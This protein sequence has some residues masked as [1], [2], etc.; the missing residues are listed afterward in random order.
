MRTS[1]LLVLSCLTAIGGEAIAALSLVN[2]KAVLP[3][4]RI[5]SSRR[6]PEFSARLSPDGKH[7]LFPQKVEGQDKTYRLVLLDIERHKETEISI[8]LPGGYE[9]VF[10]RFNF[11][12]P[13]GNKLALFYLK[14]YPSKSMAEIVIYD[15]ARNA[16]TKTNIAGRST[17]AQ[18][19]STGEHLVVSQHNSYVAL[20]TL[21]DFALG[22]PLES[23][24]VHSCSPRSPIAAI[25]QQ[26]NRSEM[27]VG[28]K[29]LNLDSKE[30][31][32]LPVHAKNSRLDDVTSQWSLDGRYIFYLDYEGGG[33][34]IPV[35][36]VWDT[37]EDQEKAAVEN[38]ICLGP[39][40][41]SRLML[42]ASADQADRGCVR[43]YDIVSESL[44]SVGDS[45]MKAVH[46]W[47]DRIIYVA[48]ENGTESLYVA[49]IIDE[50]GHQ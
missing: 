28:F 31:T 48:T 9:T 34:L 1:F 12:D 26:P 15:I 13:S 2:P 30:V 10:T 14:D 21:D 36:R 38:V 23:G 29:L 17:M 27:Q 49:E 24:W 32:Q 40:P 39:G 33:R 20:A 46:A 3:A 7:I 8:D 6:R 47:R 25:F 16:L 35:I 5:I 19:S 45:S 22:Q 18:F 44:S 41:T 43:A 37:Q 11:F 50:K 4:S 42:M